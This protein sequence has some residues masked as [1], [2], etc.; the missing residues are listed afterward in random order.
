M[1]TFRGMPIEEFLEKKNVSEKEWRDLE[2][3]DPEEYKRRVEAMQPIIDRYNS[4][5]GIFDDES[6]DK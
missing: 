5:M 2:K 4:E 6:D 1:K 3:N